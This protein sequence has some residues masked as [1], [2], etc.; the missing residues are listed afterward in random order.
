M[1]LEELWLG[2]NKITK[3]EV[4]II[5]FHFNHFF[6]IFSLQNIQA[7]AKLKILSIQSNRIT[8]LEGLETLVN[9]EQLYISH[10]GLKRL[11]GLEHNVC[12]PKQHTDLNLTCRFVLQVK[13][14]T[15][16]IGNN[17]IPAIENISHLRILEELWVTLSHV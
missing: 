13:L 9:L 15:L 6:D 11:E 5:V 8:V 12:P 10:N 16:D 17:F 1:N 3:I 4:G 2:K 14:T 7:L